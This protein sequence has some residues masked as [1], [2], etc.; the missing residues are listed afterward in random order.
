MKL[1]SLPQYTRN[2]KRFTEIVSVL[3]KYGFANWIRDTD[4][5][6]IKG[7]FKSSQGVAL[8]GVSAEG[9]IRMALTELGTTFIKLGQILSTRPDLVGPSLAKE[10]SD[11]QSEVPA[12]PP[13]AVE[14][15]LVSELGKPS[16]ALFAHFE[17]I[18]MA[19]ASIGQVHCATMHDGQ[20][21]VVKVQHMD[22]EATM[23]TDTDIL[24]TL[25]EL[26]EKHDRNLRL[27]RPR[28]LVTEVRKTLLR[29]LDF[30]REG[31]N[32]EEFN[33]NFHDDPHVH[34]PRPY[35]ELTTRKVLTMERLRGFSLADHQSVEEAGLDTKDLAERCAKLFLD[36][37]FRDNFYHADPHPG[38]LWVLKGGV[39]GMLDCGMVGR[40]DSQAR[41]DI[42][43]LLWAAMEKDAAQLTEHILRIG[44]VPQGCD[45]DGL[46]AD[47]GDFVA[48][49]VSQSLK[50]F[51]LS[52]ALKAFTQIVRRYRIVLPLGIASLMKVLVV[53]EGTSRSLNRDFSLAELLQPY[54]EET[55]QR[56]FSAERLLRRF[57]RSYR[58][59]DRFVDML[60]RELADILQRVRDGKFDVHLEH[61]RL[62]ATVNRLVYGL[63]TAAL[64]VGTCQLLSRQVPPTIGGVSILGVLGLVCTVALG[65]RL[66][67][68]VKKSGGLSQKKE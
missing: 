34:I 15:T 23:T 66:L 21:V 36:M 64:F 40:L 63:L 4:P 8:S 17:G 20:E 28:A 22:I 62:D 3:V 49:Y 58:D 57:R 14:K 5:E 38:N 45:R 6:F 48:E 43:G 1:T 19:S 35:P 60:P 2:A 54:Y 7:L 50:G 46:R 67:K 42:E 9:R 32:L 44:A 47:V 10:L 68:A 24:M 52:G 30:R 65:R 61:R 13:D 55:I 12:D 59:W 41:E 39:I 37:I 33:S 56:R 27:Y 25:A 31:R 11:L 18:P 26:A 53:L 51:D 29:E 16:S